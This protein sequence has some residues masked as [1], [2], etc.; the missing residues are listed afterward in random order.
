[1]NYRY[2]L[3]PSLRSNSNSVNDSSFDVPFII[4]GLERNFSAGQTNKV[5]SSHEYYELS[6]VVSGELVYRIKGKTVVVSAGQSMILLPFTEH[7]YEIPSQNPAEIISVYFGFASAQTLQR[8][9]SSSRIRVSP[10]S[11]AHFMEYLTGEEE[12]QTRADYFLLRG[13][14][15]REIADV[16]DRVLRY[17]G[18]DNYGKDLLMQALSTELLVFASRALKE[19]W[20]ESLKVRTGRAKELVYVARDF[21]LDNFDRSINVG[22]VADYVFLSQGYFA[23]A[24]RE[25]LG[26]S[27]MNFL[28]KVRVDKACELL[29]DEDTKVSSIAMRVGFT[30]PQRFNAAFRKQMNMTP[31]EYRQMKQNNTLE[32]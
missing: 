6:H 30:S 10:A 17:H 7:S 26:V 31:M 32:E 11:F 27:P 22:D 3:N 24:F 4:R 18:D 8:G 28:L 16:A 29:E 14:W 23:R 2:G 20:E 21:I 9:Q 15:R 12:P 1:M 5:P 19:E 13:K 25:E